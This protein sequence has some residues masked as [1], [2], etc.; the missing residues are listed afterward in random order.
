MKNVSKLGYVSSA[1]TVIGAI[2][3]GLVGSINHDLVAVLLGHGTHL[4]RAAYILVG[5]CGLYSGYKLFFS[6]STCHKTS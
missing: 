3:W 4:A 5:V 2:N 1:V 6:C